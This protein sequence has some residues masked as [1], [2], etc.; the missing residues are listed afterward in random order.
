ML[1]P[2]AYRRYDDEEGKE[3]GRLVRRRCVCELWLAPGVEHE[4]TEDMWRRIESLTVPSPPL[5]SSS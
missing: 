1:Y 2:H 5:P 3:E 4:V